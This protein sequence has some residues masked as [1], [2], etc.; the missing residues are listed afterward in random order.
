MATLIPSNGRVLHTATPSSD[1]RSCFTHGQLHGQVDA[2]VVSIE[3]F[4]GFRWNSIFY[5]L[6][7]HLS[8][9]AKPKPKVK[10]MQRF[11]YQPNKELGIAAMMIER[12]IKIR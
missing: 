4:F 2:H 5:V 8:N 12:E 6:G 10:G 11:T 3:Y 7:T 9:I 1:T